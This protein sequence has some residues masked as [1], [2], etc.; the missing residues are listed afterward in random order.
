MK[1]AIEFSTIVIDRYAIDTMQSTCLQEAGVN[2]SGSLQEE[3]NLMGLT[4]GGC[5]RSKV[6]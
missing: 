3:T 5:L 2:A 4:F 1:L 6:G